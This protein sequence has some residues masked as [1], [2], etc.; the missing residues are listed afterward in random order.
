MTLAAI[1]SL[2][3]LG[4]KPDALASA[5][6]AAPQ[7]PELLGT[8][9]QRKVARDFEAIFIRQLLSG[10]EKGG[11]MSGASSTGASM[12]KSMMV[13]SLADTAAEGGGIGLADVILKALLGAASPSNKPGL[14]QPGAVSHDATAEMPPNAGVTATPS[15]TLP[16]SAAPALTALPQEPSLLPLRSP[17]DAGSRGQAR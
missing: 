2:T 1:G 17:A 14:T 13:G 12:Y 9:E 3:A 7:K 4:Q 6:A 8:P 10:L 15:A 5:E 11:A 16:R